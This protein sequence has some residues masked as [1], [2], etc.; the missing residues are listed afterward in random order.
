VGGQIVL[1]GSTP[2]AAGLV[3]VMDCGGRCTQDLSLRFSVRSSRDLYG[4]L[5][6]ELLDAAGARCAFD[7][8]PG[9]AFSARVAA[10]VESR[11]LS[12]GRESCSSTRRLRVVLR[13]AEAGGARVAAAEFPVGWRF[14]RPAAQRSAAIVGREERVRE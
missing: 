8:V 9:R 3:P 7:A 4:S 6:I 12:L 10:T 1:I 11:F 14:V 2:E 5:Q 13:E